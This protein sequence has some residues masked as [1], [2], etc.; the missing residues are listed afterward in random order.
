MTRHRTTVT[1]TR[2][3][4]NHIRITGPGGIIHIRTDAGGIEL[5]NR[6]ID[7]IEESR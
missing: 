1:V 5:A 2:L 4:N 3:P 7:L 6:L